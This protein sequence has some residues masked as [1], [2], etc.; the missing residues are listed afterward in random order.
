MSGKK[1]V[2]KFQIE[3]QIKEL[4]LG[5]NEDQENIQQNKVELSDDEISDKISELIEQGG[6]PDIETKDG[7]KL[8]IKALEKGYIETAFIL[9]DNGA[10][11]AYERDG[12]TEEYRTS[13][14]WTTLMYAIKYFN[15][16]D[17]ILDLVKR[18]SDPNTTINTKTEDTQSEFEHTLSLRSM[19]NDELT[20]DTTPLIFSIEQNHKESTTTLLGL[21]NIEINKQTSDGKT[22][23]MAAVEDNSL[24]TLSLVAAMD[25][26]KK[27]TNLQA[28]DGWTAL[29]LATYHGNFE[30]VQHLVNHAGAEINTEPNK[31]D[32]WTPLMI[33]AYHGHEKIAKFLLEKGAD[34]D[35]IAKETIVK[36]PEE[37]TTSDQ[38]NYENLT[39]LCDRTALI[40]AVQMNHKNIA[41]ILLEKGADVNLETEN[42]LT[43]LLCATEMENEEMVEFLKANNATPNLKTKSD[44]SAFKK[45]PRTQSS[46]DSSNLTTNATYSQ[47]S[48]TTYQQQSNSSIMIASSASE[49]TITTKT[50][51][52]KNPTTSLKKL[53]KENLAQHNKTR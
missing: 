43:A 21:P 16:P 14:G 7:T 53:T 27:S 28:N 31:E 23:L 15:D 8:F 38:E 29:M 50:P 18:G 12:K 41:Q 9:I 34:V 2:S 40:C 1:T 19:R 4:I 33:A 37:K 17:L 24:T 13:N 11:I 10:E 45:P 47:E 48:D 25:I 52:P 20:I 46:F 22:A 49:D 42:G 32:S 44:P 30:I 6:S 35:Q 39:T 51:S 3:S 26:D 36:T 5:Y